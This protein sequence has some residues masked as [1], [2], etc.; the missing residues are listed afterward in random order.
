MIQNLIKSIKYPVLIDSLALLN[1]AFN[2][3]EQP[4]AGDST[5]RISFSKVKV[6]MKPF[7]NMKNGFGKIPDFKLEG[8]ATIMD[9]CQLTIQMNFVMNNPDNPFTAEGFLEPFNM[10]ILN[11]VIEPLALISLRSGHVDRFDFVFSGDRAATTGRLFFAYNDLK[12]SVFE[13]KNGNAREAKFTSFLANSLM[14]RSKNPRGKEL[15]P[16]EISFVR[17]QRRSDLNYW[18]KSVFSGIRNTLGIKET[19]SENPELPKN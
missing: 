19:K 11:P 5:G 2:Y 9:S 14:L 6:G 18:W 4:K 13:M 8:N 17:D 15:L 1:A 3:V 10:P 16:D 7:S 12:I